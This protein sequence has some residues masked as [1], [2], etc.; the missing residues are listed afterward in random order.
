MLLPPVEDY[1]IAAR[2]KKQRRIAILSTAALVLVIAIY[3]W[4]HPPL[5]QAWRLERKDTLL[6]LFQSKDE[7]YDAAV[8]RVANARMA[9]ERIQAR[10]APGTRLIGE[11][12]RQAQFEL[13]RAEI[14]LRT[15]E[16]ELI[17]LEQDMRAAGLGR[18][19]GKK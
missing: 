7:Q 2:E 19:K 11:E 13:E 16:R 5:E 6:Q 15:L 9:L 8:D 14:Q 18:K 1:E 17:V 4:L 12:E 3:G 10:R